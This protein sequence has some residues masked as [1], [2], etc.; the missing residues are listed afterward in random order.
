MDFDQLSRRWQQQLSPPAPQP[1]PDGLRAQLAS[2]PHAPIAQMRRNVWREI[3]STLL[4]GALLLAGLRLAHAPHLGLLLTLLL[5]LYG[6]IAYCY[7][8]TLQ[9]LRRLGEAAASALAGYM[10]RQLGQLRQLVRLYHGATM[11]VALV[12]LGLAGYA[13][14]RWVL[15]VVPAPATTRFLVWFVATALVS[16]G[17]THWISRYHLQNFY[18][19]HLDRLEAVL[20]ELRDETGAAPVVGPMPSGQA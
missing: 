2:R 14:V 9:V 17:A 5:P 20:H 11:L 13:A 12:V 7:F 10:A 6:G 3:G 1:G 16:Y 18:G 15:P 19:Q 8:R 4:G